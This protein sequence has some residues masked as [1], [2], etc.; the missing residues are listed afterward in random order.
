MTTG[1]Y[2]NH[3]RFQAGVI[4]D[5]RVPIESIS[6]DRTL[7][8][9]RDI[10]DIEEIV[11]SLIEEPALPREYPDIMDMVSDRVDKS[12]ELQGLVDHSTL[13]VMSMMLEVH[14]QSLDQEILRFLD[15]SI[16]SIS[17]EVTRWLNPTTVIISV[18]PDTNYKR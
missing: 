13:E 16:E 17:Y 3:R 12:K 11:E 18:N 1:A 4:V 5:L 8:L 9:I 7:W 10:F 2:K 6:K 15:P 14:Q